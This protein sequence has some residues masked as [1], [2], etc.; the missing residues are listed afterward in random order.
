[1]PPQD[2]PLDAES[3]EPNTAD[4][5]GPGEK[6]YDAVPKPD[7]LNI[8]P[9]RSAPYAGFDEDWWTDYKQRPRAMARTFYWTFVPHARNNATR[10]IVTTILMLTWATVTL[11]SAFG[12]AETGQYY[13]WMTMA[14]FAIVCTIWGFEMGMLDAAVNNDLQNTPR[15]TDGGSDDE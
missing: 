11:G 9:D 12:F 13:P 2:D 5:D 8:G 10:K 6:L 3:V 7:D 14:V 15:Q 4:G 1:M